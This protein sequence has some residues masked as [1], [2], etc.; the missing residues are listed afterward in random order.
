MVKEV[1]ARLW[2]ILTRFTTSGDYWKKRYKLGG[3]S[4]FGS[5]TDFADFKATVV[6]HVL[7]TYQILDAIEFGCGDGH[8]LG[9]IKYQKYLGLDIS[10]DALSRC[11][12]A[13]RDDSSKRFSLLENFE[14][15]HA[16]ITISMDVIYHLVEDDVFEKHMAALFDH[17][18]RFV[19]IYS[20]NCTDSPAIKLPH[21]RNR[22]FSE[23]I[24]RHQPSWH[25]VAL[26]IESIAEPPRKNV[27]VRADFFL[28]Q[29]T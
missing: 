26:D 16:E 25:L 3:H 23:W 21:V 10:P 27:G 9:M 20:S 14:N 29:K 4:G 6:N 13:Y 24:D 8:Q 18:I 28:Y 7:E 19:L 2:P 22:T 15:S 11:Q 5:R 17:A 1:L 12:Q